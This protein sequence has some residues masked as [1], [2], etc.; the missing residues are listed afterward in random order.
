MKKLLAIIPIFVFANYYNEGLYAY[1][2]K[3]YS[4]AKIYFKLS[5]EKEKN[6]WGCFSYAQM[7]NNIEEKNQYIKK[8]CDLGLKAACKK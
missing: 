6:A 4:K 1:L 5:C 2:A 7:I 8:A 3:N